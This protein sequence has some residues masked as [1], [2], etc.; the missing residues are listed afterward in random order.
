MT[1]TSSGTRD[2]VHTV[3]HSCL[4]PVIDAIPVLE[5]TVGFSPMTTCSHVP[6]P[7]HDGSLPLAEIF[8]LAQLP[9]YWVTITVS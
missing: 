3:R 4:V 8:L 5:L 2:S 9:Y 6:T 1:T 7:D